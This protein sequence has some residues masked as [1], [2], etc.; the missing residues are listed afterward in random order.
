MTPA[1]FFDES[2]ICYSCGVPGNRR[3]LGPKRE[4]AFDSDL[5][6]R[7]HLATVA[8]QTERVSPCCRISFAL[9]GMPPR[10]VRTF[11]D[12]RHLPLF[13]DAR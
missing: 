10:A 9:E 7:Q 3:R 13:D 1:S 12:A 6:I 8:P 5:A 2:R 4:T 11:S